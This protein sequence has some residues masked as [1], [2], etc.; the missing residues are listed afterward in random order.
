MQPL[1]FSSIRLWLALAL[2]VAL[3][4]IH[5][6]DFGALVDLP[7]AQRDNPPAVTPATVDQSVEE[8]LRGY[9]LAKYRNVVDDSLFAV[10]AVKAEPVA[11]VEPEP[12]PEPPPPPPPKAPVFTANLEVTGIVITPERKLVMVWDKNRKE[13]NVLAERETIRRWR[14]VSIDEQRVVLHHPLG[15]R[16]EF[17][18]NEETSVNFNN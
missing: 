3:A 5:V 2:L 15:G 8:A 14:V 13:T 1:S 17:I 9:A 18:V 12:K 16:Y 6:A 7:R 11:V 4:A 10:N